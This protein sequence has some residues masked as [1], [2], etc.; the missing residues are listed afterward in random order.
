MFDFSKMTPQDKA[1]LLEHLEDLRKGL[2]VSIVAIIIASIPAFYYSDLILEFIKQP[3][4]MTKTELNFTG[5]F[6]PFYVKITLSLIGGL[7][8][9]FPVVAWQIWGFMAPA[10][11]PSER[12]SVIILFPAIIALFAAGVLFGY[13][14]IMPTA[15]YFLVVVM[16]TGLNPIITVDDYVNKLLAFTIPFGLVFELPIVVYFLTRLR[17][18]KPEM[19]SKNRKYAVLAIAVL[20]AVLTPGPDPVSQCLLGVPIYLLYE[21]SI[22]VSKLAR[23]KPKHEDSTD[24]AEKSDKDNDVD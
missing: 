12:R 5:V 14:V 9:S 1:T 13:L 4:T 21:I 11:Y 2:I 18:I 7:I 15:L 8:L 3:L 19:L 20:S 6:T 16:G 10:L 24:L 23:P 17:I 22:V